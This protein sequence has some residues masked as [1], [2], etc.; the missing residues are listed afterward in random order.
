M[1][2][3]HNRCG[4]TAMISSGSTDPMEFGARAPGLFD[5]CVIGLTS[6]LPNNWLGLRLAIILRRLVTMR[7]RHPDGALDV[8]R[9]GLQLRLHPRDNGCEKGLLFTPQMY[10]TLELA[11]LASEVDRIGGGNSALVFLDIGANV[12]LFSFFVAARSGARARVLAIEPEKVNLERLLFNL[13]ANP[14]LPIRVVPAALGGETGRLE[15]EPDM[16]DRGGTLVRQGGSQIV[17]AKTLLQLLTEEAVES[18]DA[19]K[20]DVE[21]MEDVILIPFFRDAPETL[22]PRLIL[23]EDAQPWWNC[24]LFALLGRKGYSMSSRSR[25]N[26]VLRRAAGVSRA[27]SGPQVDVSHHG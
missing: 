3:H 7:L 8:V 5:R 10:E 14:G 6:H 12:G 9:W 22:W 19:I 21:G 26:V 1:L 15:I 20:I 2:S 27:M 16:R 25:Q 4:D 23:I 17:E 18:V 24:D 11:E 13:R